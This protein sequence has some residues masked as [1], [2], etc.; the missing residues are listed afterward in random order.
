MNRRSRGIVLATSAILAASG[1]NLALQGPS[2][3]NATLEEAAVRTAVF[4]TRDAEDT[5]AKL[6]ADAAMPSSTATLA[7]PTDTPSQTLTPT[8][9]RV[10]ITLSKNTNCRAGPDTQFDLVGVMKVGEEAEAVGR[11]EDGT[12]FVIH[13][14]SNPAKTCW[15]WSQW[16]AADGNAEGL[17]V[18][19]SPATP[20]Y[21]P[22]PDLT[23]TY[24]GITVC[25]PQYALK[26]QVNNTGNVALES[27]RM[28][29]EDITGGSTFT[30]IADLFRWYNG[31]G[32]AGSIDP[33]EPGASAVVSNRNP[34]QFTYDPAG[35]N[36]HVTVRVCT[37][38]GL[39]GI[40]QES[41]V[42]FTV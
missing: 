18:M 31:C 13:L 25:A 40:C 34:G 36:L 26:I 8:S 30:H 22:R 28:T 9:G 27:V 6:A 24:L 2:G 41:D 4:Q 35:H 42:Y 5:A 11:N 19:P 20:T 29:V 15:L 38:D 3:V 16:A 7:L 10:M 39:A 1:C 21:Y 33:L 32:V 12:Y 14:P 17:P 23:L 37:E